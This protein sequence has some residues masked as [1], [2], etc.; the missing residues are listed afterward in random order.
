MN[1]RK[2][3]QTSL[4]ENNKHKSV[5]IETFQPHLSH[6]CTPALCSIIAPRP[7]CIVYNYAKNAPD[8]NIGPT[9][10]LYLAKVHFSPLVSAV[11]TKHS[12]KPLSSLSRVAT[13]RSPDPAYL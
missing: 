6:V 2:K 9:K 1:F 10:V 5:N 3:N 4:F 12:T 8:A 11:N 7:C 13:A